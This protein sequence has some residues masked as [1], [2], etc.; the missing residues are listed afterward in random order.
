MRSI[1]RTIVP[2]AACLGLGAGC[3]PDSS[4]E[5]PPITGGD[6]GS[7][8]SP[9]TTP[10]A[11]VAAD[12]GVSAATDATL[13]AR[14]GPGS[15]ASDAA[16][17]GSQDTG[18][19]PVDAGSGGGTDAGSSSDASV[20]T[21]DAAVG[22]DAGP[23]PSNA[24]A[25]LIPHA[26]WPC[27][28]PDGIPPPELGT[29]AFEATFAVNTKHEV[30]KTQYGTR[31]LNQLGTGSVTGPMLQATLLSGG[32]E[33]IVTLDN[34][35]VEMEQVL[36]LRAGS[37]S[38]YMRMCGVSANSAD[39]VRVVPDIEA[40]N[41]SHRALQSA[42]LAGVRTLS[43]DGKEIKLRV[44]DVSKVAAPGATVKVERPAG[45]PTENWECDKASG[46]Q[47]TEVFRETVQIGS[48]ISVGTGKRG[49]RNVIP[50]TGGTVSGK[51]MGTILPLGG[52]FQL[53]TGGF[54]LDARY[55]LKGNQGDLVLVRN[56]GP[57]G[58]LVPVFETKVGGAYDYLNEK[59]YLS[60]DPSIGLGTVSLT[61]YEKR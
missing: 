2:L 7:G 19:R 6:S 8:M 58:A 44:F 17:G 31:V 43:A 15:G 53:L 38:I 48:S 13:D 10:D 56:C 54:V 33:Q 37:A 41:S 23:A 50:I 57:V 51:V 42:K 4:D 27:M 52:D 30:G 45:T 24:D 61:L 5:S 60:S 40:P 18:T 21:P 16:S 39:P 25:T 32:F 26:S 29:L 22:S 46:S 20:S 55:V 49:N 59:K 35:A 1:F 3:A 28:M 36:M 12:A 14:P 11:S 9:V 47:G 34:G